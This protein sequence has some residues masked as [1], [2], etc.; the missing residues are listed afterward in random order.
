MKGMKGVIFIISVLIA[1]LVLFIG[2][3]FIVNFV[4]SRTWNNILFLLLGE[5]FVYILFYKEIFY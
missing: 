5:V 2:A 3:I 4:E 1:F